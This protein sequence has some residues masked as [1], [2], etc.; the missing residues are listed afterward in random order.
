MRLGFIGVGAMGKPM[1]ANLLKAGYQL[2]VNDV[3]E[4]AISELVGEGAVK[5]HT[6]RE[7]ALETDVVITMLPNSAIV[8]SVMTGAEG[9]FAGSRPGQIIIDMSSVDPF[10]TKNMAAAAER[11]GF[12]YVD[13]PVSGGVAGATS[14]SLTIMVG[15]EKEAV[16]RIEP[17]LKVLGQKIYHVGQVGSGDAVKVINNLLLGVNMAALGEAL[18]L[19]VKAG[20]D[21]NTMYDII[22]VSSGRSYAVETKLPNFILKGSFDP[23]FAIDLQYKDLELAIATA[24]KMGMPLPMTNIAQQVFEMARAQGL[25]KEDISAVIKVWEEMMGAL[26][27]SQ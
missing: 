14:G 20:L 1:A 16:A 9:V 18:V 21:P 11:K 25:G 5:C 8:E 26:V 4:A 15:G 7:A 6:P 19:G 12:I 3:N 2:Q 22:K 27:R 10:F 17:L 24:K 13:A 23:G